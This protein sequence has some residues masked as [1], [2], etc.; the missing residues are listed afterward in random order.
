LVVSWDRAP[1]HLDAFGSPLHRHVFR[2][3]IATRG[4]SSVP[5][6]GRYSSSRLPRGWRSCLANANWRTGTGLGRP[7]R[8]PSPGRLI[9]DAF[10]TTP[11]KVAIVSTRPRAGAGSDLAGRCASTLRPGDA[12]GRASDSDKSG[13]DDSLLHGVVIRVLE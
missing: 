13:S 4:S 3:A 5:T 10:R 7:P 8:R 11:S 2:D 6:P 9:L 12:G 1:D